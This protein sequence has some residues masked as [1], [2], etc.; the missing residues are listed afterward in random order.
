MSSS[1]PGV[2]E[3][4]CVVCGAEAHGI[5]FQVNSCRACAAFFRRSAVCGKKYKCRRASYNC[6][7]SKDAFQQCRRCRYQKCQEVGMTLEGV[8]QQS[9]KAPVEVA[10]P[11]HRTREPSDSSPLPHIASSGYRTGTFN[12]HRHTCNLHHL[13]HSI[14]SI[15]EGQ[16]QPST[17][18]KSILQPLIDAFRIPKP[19]NIEVMESVDFGVY[20]TFFHEDLRRVA[21]WM[22]CS[23]H[24]AD[25]PTMDKWRMFCSF[26]SAYRSIER[27][28]RTTEFLGVDC[29]LAVVLFTENIAVNLSSFRL[30]LGME[31]AKEGAALEHVNSVN[32]CMLNTFVIPM[33]NLELTTEEV[34][35]LLLYKMW[36]VQYVKG[37]SQSTYEIADDVLT[38]ICDEIHE[39]YTRKMKMVNYS[40]RFS[41]IMRLLTEL[42]GFLRYRRNAEI[43]ADVFGI[44][45]CE[46]KDSEFHGADGE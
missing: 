36:S 12:G 33:K 34:V 41:Q 39:Y 5:H 16:D 28:A 6:D 11:R 21:S 27:C 4:L 22:M 42:E 44:F 40:L 10:E 13:K 8:K 18:S 14:I 25:L 31:E 43:T 7:V 35:F 32:L 46:L 24:F 9:K 30:K 2:S 15:L 3:S 23:N 1:P 19:D 45:G 26:W 29:P 38:R 37:L 20:I 17:S